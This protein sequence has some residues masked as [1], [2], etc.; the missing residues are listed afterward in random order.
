MENLIGLLGIRRMD[1]VPNAERRELC[2][3]KK[4][5]DERIDDGILWWFSHL[6][7]MEN[8]RIAKR[9]YVRKCAG[10]C[11]VGRPRK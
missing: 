11:S 1:R 5:V 7:R 8:D 3:V 9:V 4:G 6:E 2:R 10:S